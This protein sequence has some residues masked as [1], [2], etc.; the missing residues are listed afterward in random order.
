MVINARQLY[1]LRKEKENTE[2]IYNLFIIPLQST[3]A[4]SQEIVYNKSEVEETLFQNP[5]ILNP[6]YLLN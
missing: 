6:P 4:K 3:L 5:P 2:K 1:N